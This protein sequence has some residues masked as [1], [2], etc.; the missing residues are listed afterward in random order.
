MTKI[1]EEVFVSPLIDIVFKTMWLRADD[2]LKAYFNRVLT[3]ALRRDFNRFTIGP[4]ETGITDVT[5]IANKV[6]VLL[7]QDDIKVDVE[8]NNAESNSSISSIMNKSLVY[9]SYYITTYYDNDKDN[10][11]KKPIKVEQINLNNFHCPEGYQI[12]RLDYK[13]TDTTNEISFEGIEYH[14]I[15][16]PRMKEI[17]YSNTKVNDIYKDYAMLL[18]KSYEEMESL[19]GSD[20]A[21]LAFIKMLK[22]LGRDG[23]MID[24][25]RRREDELLIEKREAHEK[26]LKEGKEEGKEQGIQ[27][28]IQEGL[29][30][31]IQEGIEQN[32]RKMIISMKANDISIEKIAKIAEISVDD[33]NKIL[34]SSKEE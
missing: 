23:K 18:C 13:F 28:G 1:K 7:I 8:L 5:N 10:K 11:Y 19:A 25:L 31:G 2:D 34:E 9:L 30:E 3:W 33:V 15:Y 22:M 27:E 4:N 20:P 24:A 29:Q 16:L 21:R 14:H 12:E 17:C 32:K 26:G 6:D